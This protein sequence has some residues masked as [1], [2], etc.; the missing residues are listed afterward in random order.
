MEPCSNVQLWMG[1]TTRFGLRSRAARLC[2]VPDAPPR[3]EGPASAFPA[4]ART[5]LSPSSAPRSRGS[6]ARDRPRRRGASRPQF[7]TSRADVRI[8]GPSSPLFARRYRG[9]PQKICVNNNCEIVL[10]PL[11]RR[12]VMAG[13]G[14]ASCANFGK[15]YCFSFIID[16]T[17]LT[18]DLCQ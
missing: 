16:W 3:G 17:L 8:T 4:R 9:D 11:G 15:P 7:G 5:G 14:A 2:G 10:R 18:E 6:R 13:P 12:P 1:H